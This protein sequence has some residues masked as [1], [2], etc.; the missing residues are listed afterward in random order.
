MS[1]LDDI[2]RKGFVRVAL[3]HVRPERT[4]DF[5]LSDRIKLFTAWRNR[6]GG[7]PDYEGTNLLGD[8]VAIDMMNVALI[9]TISPE[10]YALWEEDNEGKPP[11]EQ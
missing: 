1:E 10:S 9:I 2:Y 6:R 8:P 5:P 3:K 11:W 4:V 7:S